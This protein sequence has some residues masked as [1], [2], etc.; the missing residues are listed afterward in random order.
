[1]SEDRCEDDGGLPGED[2]RALRQRNEARREEIKARTGNQVD[3]SKVN[4]RAEGYREVLAGRGPRTRDHDMHFYAA[5]LAITMRLF[6]PLVVAGKVINYAVA[7][8]FLAVV[9]WGVAMVVEHRREPVVFLD[10]SVP[11]RDVP[12]GGKVEVRF[13]IFRRLVCQIS[14]DYAILGTDTSG[15]V[16]RK[17]SFAAQHMDVGGPPGHDPFVRSFDLPKDMAPGPA[18]FRP[19][20]SWI[21]PT[22]FVDLFFPRIAEV[23]DAPFMVRDGIR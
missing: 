22:N 12:V 15:N 11:Q 13:D 23:R 8:V 19:A 3:W 1:M 6:R 16:D 18:R 21:C 4:E 17:W 2:W 9:A 20:W 5:T 14:P 7:V 10:I